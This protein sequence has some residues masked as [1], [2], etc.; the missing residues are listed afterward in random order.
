MTELVSESPEKK[1]VKSETNT[2]YTRVKL[3]GGNNAVSN[4]CKCHRSSVVVLVF[5]LF[6]PIIMNRSIVKKYETRRDTLIWGYDHER[7][8]RLT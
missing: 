5:T 6:S 3:Y 2:Q 1:R 7:Y 8:I 4:N